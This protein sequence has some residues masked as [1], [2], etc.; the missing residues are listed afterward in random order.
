M[1]EV[2]AEDPRGDLTCMEVDRLGNGVGGVL[3]V[4]LH[5]LP[6]LLVSIPLPGDVPQQHPQP[7]VHG[8]SP[9][10]V[11]QVVELRH[12]FCSL[13]IIGPLESIS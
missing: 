10:C 2:H 12:C 13:C 4:S 9:H 3:N 11:Y 5:P 6:L 8:T 1:E 7:D